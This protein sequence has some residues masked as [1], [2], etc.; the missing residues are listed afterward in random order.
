MDY[1]TIYLARHGETDW[2]NEQRI[3]GHTDIALNQKG[4]TQAQELAQHLKEI[5]FDAAFSSDLLRAKRTAEIIAE[6]R[7]L[8]ITTTALLREQCFGEF[9]GILIDEYRER[10][11]AQL[12]KLAA[13]KKDQ[14]KMNFKINET[15]ES[16]SESA[17]RALLFIREISIAYSNMTILMVCHGALMRNILMTLGVDTYANLDY[18]KVEIGNTAYIKMRCDGVDF[19]VDVV[20]KITGIKHFESS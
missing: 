4:I 5:H 20:H 16:R 18:G 14:E 15:A 12:D 3:Q 10:A 19:F 7:K 6:E 9:E 2:N 11:K 1:C 17:S 13:L 8:V